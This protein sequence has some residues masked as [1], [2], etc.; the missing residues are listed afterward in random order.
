MTSPERPNI[1][2]FMSED[3]PPLNSAYG[4]TLADTPTIQRMADEGVLFENGM[5]TSP[6]C[7]PS[8]FAV[9]TGMYAETCGP[10]HQMRAEAVI[11]ASIRTFAEIAKDA[12]Y[13]CTNNYKTDYNARIDP[14]QIWDE[15]SETAHWKNRPAGSPFL[16]FVNDFTTHESAVFHMPITTVK[17]EDVSVPSYLPD[18]EAVRFDI[19]RYYTAINRMDANFGQQLDELDEAGLLENT[20]VI[21]TS[22]HGSVIARS[23]RFCYDT[24][25]KIPFIV[26]FPEKFDSMSRW[27]AGSRVTTAVSQIDLPPSILSMIGE[28]IPDTMQGTALFGSDAAEPAGLAFSGRNRMDERYDIV[29]TVR[30]ERFR[31]VRNY[32]PHRPWLQYQSFAWQAKNYQSFEI[33]HR[34]G[35]LDEVAERYWEEKPAEEL[36]DIAADPEEVDNLA[37]LPEHA[38]T[39][40]KF[41]ALLRSHIVRI[42]DN[43]FIPEGAAVEGYES[44][45][46]AG[47][48]PIEDVLDIADLAIERN[49]KNIAVFVGGLNNNDESIRWWAAR[50][51][52]MLKRQASPAATT[53]QTSLGDQSP[54]VRVVV[55]EALSW[56]GDLGTAVAALAEL[57]DPSNDWVVRVQ[58]INALTYLPSL[59]ASV[60][61]AIESCIDDGVLEVRESARYLDRLVRDDHDPSVPVFDVKRFLQEIEAKAT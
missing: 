57:C 39:V 27:Q 52:L 47:A 15:S 11:P 37:D 6:V 20:I 12:G 25:L 50:G 42:N 34:A 55:A 26:R 61:S 60:G 28:P 19:A 13:Y 56:V 17:P 14:E 7:A 49:P 41:R 48:Y 59:P 3:A 4:D 18:T 43:G 36:Y 38:E 40:A 46:V 2:W 23:K 30:T 1:F 29:R 35:R 53:L 51:L 32:S 31:Y 44:S 24:G 8:R 54:Q 58:A 22:D 9:I 16:H 10:A 21:H 45:R 33:E 5:C